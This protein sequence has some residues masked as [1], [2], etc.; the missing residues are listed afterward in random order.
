MQSN[1][2]HSLEDLHGEGAIVAFI[3]SLVA[4]IVLL[5]IG[6]PIFVA[7]VAFIISLCITEGLNYFFTML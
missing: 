6:C 4:T 1:N 2:I 3:L 7:I 5:I